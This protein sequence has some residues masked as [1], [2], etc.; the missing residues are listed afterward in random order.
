MPFRFYLT[1]PTAAFS[2]L[3]G[4]VAFLSGACA[5][6]WASTAQRSR[7]HG[8]AFWAAKI[9]GSQDHS[10]LGVGIVRR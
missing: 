9:V 2:G 8:E 10:M 4:L 3:P 7:R 1:V 5:F 6:P